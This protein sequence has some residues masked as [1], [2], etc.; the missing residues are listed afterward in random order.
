[1]ASE[2]AASMFERSVVKKVR[3]F[4]NS[5][6][7]KIGM[8][9]NLDILRKKLVD[10]FEMEPILRAKIRTEKHNLKR[11]ASSR[12]LTSEEEQRLIKKQVGDEM[13]R[14]IKREYMFRFRREIRVNS[15][16]SPI[17]VD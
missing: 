2:L 3:I 6:N 4:L 10:D 11:Q 1:M 7:H 14:I 5:T 15:A 17:N 8:Q 13:M 16:S 9:P 12:A